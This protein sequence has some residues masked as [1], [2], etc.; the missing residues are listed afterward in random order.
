[1]SH[2]DATAAT[3]PDRFRGS[4]ASRVPHEAARLVLPKTGFDG[5]ATGWPACRRPRHAGRVRSPEYHRHQRHRV[6]SEDIDDLHTAIIMAD[7]SLLRTREDLE[8]L[9]A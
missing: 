8:V 4:H 9:L 7:D 1:M 6:V 5:T 3:A 2:S